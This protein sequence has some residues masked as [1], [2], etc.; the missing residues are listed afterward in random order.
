MLQRAGTMPVG[1]LSRTGVV[2]MLMVVIQ[3]NFINEQK[4]KNM[5]NIRHKTR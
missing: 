1:I 4:K 3:P 2:K 5:R